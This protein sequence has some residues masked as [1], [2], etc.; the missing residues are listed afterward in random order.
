MVD[1]RIVVLIR[2]KLANQLTSGLARLSSSR[3]RQGKEV[4]GVMA[5]KFLGKVIAGAALGGASL[6]DRAG[7]RGR[8]RRIRPRSARPPRQD[9]RPPQ[10]GQSGHEVTIVGSA[11]SRRSTPG[12]G[13]R[14]P[15]SSAL[16]PRTMPRAQRTATGTGTA[17]RRARRTARTTRRARRTR[18]T[19]P[20]AN[21]TRSLKEGSKQP[22]DQ[23]YPENK[24]NGEN[25]S[26]T[27]SGDELGS[28]AG[29][30]DKSTAPKQD[31][32]DKNGHSENKAEDDKK[33][34]GHEEGDKR[35]EHGAPRSD[36]EDDKWVY[37]TTV[38]IPWD[39]KPGRTS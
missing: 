19:P 12:H 8:G 16:R 7:H 4:Q 21:Q 23:K 27:P 33:G 3:R 26:H 25:G 10:V 22:S 5:R 14:S 6:L 30:D 13:R 32:K 9:L 1:K 37:A 29:K 34:K 18:Q 20:R 31:Y 11:Q 17:S 36:D 28:K 24:E 2:R 39:T 35:D 15:A 38:T